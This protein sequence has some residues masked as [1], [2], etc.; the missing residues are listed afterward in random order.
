[1]ILPIENIND[2]FHDFKKQ[3]MQLESWNGIL[4]KAKT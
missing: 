1:L 3:G 4:Y 2:I